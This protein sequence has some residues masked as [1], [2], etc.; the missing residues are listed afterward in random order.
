[1]GIEGRG[2][3]MRNSLSEQREWIT[4]LHE[5]EKS[6]IMRDKAIE[7]LLEQGILYNAEKHY[8]FTNPNWNKRDLVD[9]LVEFKELEI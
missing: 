4:E 9:L 7:F 1:M 6:T 2:L 3:R 8:I 5:M